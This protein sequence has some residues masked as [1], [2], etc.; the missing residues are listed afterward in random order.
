MRKWI[1]SGRILAIILSLAIAVGAVPFPVRAAD[2]YV[3]RKADVAFVI[4]AT[5]S[6]GGCISSVKSNI[7]NFINLIAKEDVDVRVKFVIYRDMTY[8][9]AEE[10]TTSSDWYSASDSASSYLTDV[11]A[12]GG[13]DEE[14][15]LLDG[16]GM[17]LSGGF[18]S[19]A[20]KYCIFFT[21]VATKI[22]NNYGYTSEEQA[23]AAVNNAGIVMSMVT[24]N[25]LFDAYAN[26]V[27]SDQGGIMADINGDYNILLKNLADTIIGELDKLGGLTMS[28]RNCKE[29]EDVTVKVTSDEAAEIT[30]AGDFKIFFDGEEVSAISKESSYF[31]FKVPP[32]KLFGKYEVK[33]INSGETRTIGHFTIE[34]A[35]EYGT[36][37]PNATVKGTAVTVRVPVSKLNYQKDFSVALGGKKVTVGS[38][39]VDYFEFKVPSSLGVKSYDVVITN[40]GQKHY[41]GEFIVNA[42]IPEFGTMDVIESIV[43]TNTKVTVPV[44]NMEYQSDFAVVMNGI[45]LKVSKYNEKICFTVPST[46]EVGNFEVQVTNDKRTY[47]L[48]YFTVKEKEVPI[49]EMG[50]MDIT[51]T[52]KGTSVKV[53]VPVKNMTY[54]E[55]F[56]LTFNGT[57]M[58]T[59]KYTDFFTF[60]VPASMEVGDYPVVVRNN[61]VSYDLGIFSVKAKP[62][63]VQ[64][65][66]MTA[67]ESEEGKTAKVDV[68]AEGIKY[69]SD[70]TVALNGTAVKVTRYNN[71]FIF[72]VLA[73]TA[74]GEYDVTVINDGVTYN[75]GKYTVKGKTIPTPT[76]TM[77]SNESEEGKAVKVDIAVSN[78]TYA[79]D[80][81]VTMNDKKVSIAKYSSYFRISIPASM[82][83][84]E[85]TITVKNSG[86]SYEVGKYTIKA[87]VV[88]APTFK[89]S[90]TENE[91]GTTTKVDV[92][93]TDLAYAPDFAVT[94]NGA[95]V[96]VVKYNNHFIFTVLSS[97][98]AGD[99]TVTVN[100]NGVK[101]DLGKYTVKSK[102]ATT[103]VEDF[104]VMAEA[105][106]ILEK[107]V[108]ASD[109]ENIQN[110]E[111]KSEETDTEDISQ[112]DAVTD[113]TEIDS[114][115]TDDKVN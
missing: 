53:T 18:R 30:Y 38:K 56:L 74:I 96:K 110:D 113:N 39:E 58:K 13:G 37:T 19:D 50:T 76:F 17:M 41:L 32:T 78:M 108:S 47:S 54:A 22:N 92:V 84:G 29:G 81:I 40:G 2:L 14:E 100:N 10:M 73:S 46:M 65:F 112:S 89:M 97:M 1:F 106:D 86:K 36:M 95:S 6:M 11:E 87:K 105:E 82:T 90:V 101:Y 99:Y 103:S 91:E 16:I 51:E 68:T 28:P 77:K 23:V 80:F 72:T 70:F 83:A 107:T 49:P 62:V 34:S 48:G 115:V 24:A 44:S 26:Y 102:T 75:L 109:E 69:A 114:C 35:A 8:T 43:G 52:E 85:Y 66:T 93:T 3:E 45:T 111:I 71:H 94:M 9:Q 63:P 61:A 4:D 98:P 21:D 67:T 59:V 33:V 55:D 42:K 104:S 31:E 60:T 79:S 20:V 25:S 64:T 15:T 12:I 5:G 27:S 7:T 57:E 88:P